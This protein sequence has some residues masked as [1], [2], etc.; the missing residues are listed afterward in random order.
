VTPAP[1]RAGVFGIARTTAHPSP[2]ASCSDAAETPAAIDSSR[3]A[4][5]AA[6]SL[7]I[8]VASPGFTATI[9]ASQ[10]PTRSATRNPG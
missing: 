3:R 7:A 5:W 4:P 1:T 9:P 2:A 10:E 6:S 8:V